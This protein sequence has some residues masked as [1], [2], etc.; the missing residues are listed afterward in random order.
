MDEVIKQMP[1][2]CLNIILFSTSVRF[3]S[4]EDDHR[5]DFFDPSR[6]NIH[7]TSTICC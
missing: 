1:S 6:K 3:R 4:V 7:Y 5:V 2:V